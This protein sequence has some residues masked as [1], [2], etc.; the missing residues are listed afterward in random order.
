MWALLIGVVGGTRVAAAGNGD[1]VAAA[2]ARCSGAS[3]PLPALTADQ[4]GA[5]DAGEVVRIVQHGDPEAPSTAIGIAVLNA[6]RDALWIAAQDP[7]AQVDPS[8]TE[9]VIRDLGSDH[10]VWY[11]Y[12]D[13]PRPL[14]DRQWVVESRNS[15]ALATATGGACWEHHWTLQP[16]ALDPIRAMV[17]RGASEG[18]TREQIDT[19]IYTPVNHGGWLMAPLSDGKVMV[20]YQATS[21]V[22]GAVP[23]WLV[24]QLTMARL[25]SVLRGL[26]DRARSWSVTHYRSGHEAVPGGAGEPIATFP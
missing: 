12:M 4:R 1:E 18:L 8:L 2:I 19:A 6:S 16:E 23:D 15:H 9:F 11:G 5:L 21:V 10:A 17:D 13:L 25:E 7:H 3:H 22:G 26:E 20:S 24:L 14:K